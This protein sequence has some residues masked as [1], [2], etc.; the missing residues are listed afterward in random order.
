MNYDLALP[1]LAS[2]AAVL[3]GVCSQAIMGK[4]VSSE[5][6]QQ[7]RQFALNLPAP[8]QGA[9]QDF[10]P[11]NLQP[12]FILLKIT[13]VFDGAQCLTVA[14]SL[15]MA[16]ISLG[17]SN[18]TLNVVAGISFGTLSMVWF[19]LTIVMS[20]VSYSRFFHPKH[21]WFISFR[22]PLL[23]RVMYA[24]NGWAW[25]S[26]VAFTCYVALGIYAL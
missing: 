12:P 18:T 17:E 19:T 14:L 25:P 20:D 7:V 22:R 21:L 26:F 24:D 3:V 9:I 15:I 5:L 6:G 10:L 11:S 8:T 2:A 1:F 16:V 23:R 13:R 4:T